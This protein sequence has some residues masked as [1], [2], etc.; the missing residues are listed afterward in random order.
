ML[1]HYEGYLNISPSSLLDLCI[2]VIRIKLQGVP[3]IEPS[4]K[5][6][7]PPDKDNKNK[8]ATRKNKLPFYT[9]FPRKHLVK[10]RGDGRR[11][12]SLQD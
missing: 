4:K 3:K 7:S 8:T 9:E 1:N 12:S 11:G 5:S 6:S 10:C 2:F